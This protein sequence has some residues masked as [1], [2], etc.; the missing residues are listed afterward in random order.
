MEFGA[1]IAGV[2]DDAFTD[3][4]GEIEAAIGRMA[5]F[6]VRD[7]AQGVEVVVEVETIVLEFGIEGFFSGVAEGRVADVVDEGESFSE[8]GVEAKSFGEGAGDLRDF[9]SVGE[10]AAEVVAELG[11][12]LAREDLGFSGESA[13]GAGVEDAGAIA[14]EVGAVRMRGLRESACGERG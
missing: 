2:L 13:E 12:G 14:G 8:I 10:A 11:A 1:V 5:L 3:G 6:E 9:K 7:D 4:E